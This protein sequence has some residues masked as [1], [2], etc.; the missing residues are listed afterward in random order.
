MEVG[1]EVDT[2]WRPGGNY[3]KS[4]KLSFQPEGVSADTEHNHLAGT[5]HNQP[6]GKSASTGN[7]LSAGTKPSL[8][9]GK[10]SGTENHQSAGTKPNPSAGKSGESATADHDDNLSGKSVSIKHQGMTG[11]QEQY[12][13]AVVN[14]S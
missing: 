10:S 3:V 5:K 13:C 7:H 6:A 9:A 12:K 14:K 1:T 4:R 11:I 8:L 2:Q